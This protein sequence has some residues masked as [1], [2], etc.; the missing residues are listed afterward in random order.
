VLRLLFWGVQYHPEYGLHDVAA[1]DADGRRGGLAW[2]FALVRDILNDDCRRTE[3][4]N[5]IA[6]LEQT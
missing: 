3:L 1:L 5:W 6:S 2:R 4:K